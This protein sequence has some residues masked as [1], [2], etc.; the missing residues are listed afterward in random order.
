MEFFTGVGFE[1]STERK[2]NKQQTRENVARLYASLAQASQIKDQRIKILE[3]ESTMQHAQIKMLQQCHDEKISN[4]ENI[5]ETLLELLQTHSTPLPGSLR[6][7]LLKECP[8]ALD[9]IVPSVLN[10]TVEVTNKIPTPE[11]IPDGQQIPITDSLQSA[12]HIADG[13]FSHVLTFDDIFE[14]NMNMPLGKDSE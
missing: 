3:Q 2:P 10:N 7:R 8:Q 6:K 14:D 1:H 13:T 11:S 12:P 9:S 4:L 5:I